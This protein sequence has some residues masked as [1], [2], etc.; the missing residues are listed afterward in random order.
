MKKDIDNSIESQAEQCEWLDVSYTA[1]KYSQSD[2]VSD[3]PRKP[4]F[5]KNHWKILALSVLTVFVFVSA[6]FVST[7]G[8]WDNVTDI[9]L[10]SVFGSDNATGTNS[11]KYQTINLPYN[12]EIA[13]VDDGVVTFGGGSIVVSFTDGVVSA[14]SDGTVSVDIDSQTTIVYGNIAECYV[15]VGAQLDYCD[16]IGKYTESASVSIVNN[17]IAI[18]D[19]VGSDYILQW[20]V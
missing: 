7:N 18:T 8:N 13:S 3:N 11:G 6:F 14:V 19:V 15:V 16:V 12:V 9:Y 5:R 20:S 2:N 1:R 4:I 17:D 10:S